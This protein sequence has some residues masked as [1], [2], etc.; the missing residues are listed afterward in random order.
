MILNF[1]YNTLST[2]KKNIM[3][4]TGCSDA[5]LQQV[6]DEIKNFYVSYCNDGTAGQME[7]DI[8]RIDLD[9]LQMDTETNPYI[10][11]KIHMTMKYEIIHF[12]RALITY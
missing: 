9:L 12:L 1:R 6:L 4:I 8:M 11:Q 2:V 10:E 5:Q 7:V 3:A